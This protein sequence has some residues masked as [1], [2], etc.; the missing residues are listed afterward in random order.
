MDSDNKDSTSVLLAKAKIETK[1][2][3][4]IVHM[5]TCYIKRFEEGKGIQFLT[6]IICHLFQTVEEEK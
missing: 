4:Q 6:G 3:K 5:H 1:G 2:E